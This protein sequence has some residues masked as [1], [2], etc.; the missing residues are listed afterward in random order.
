MEDSQKKTEEAKEGAE[1]P[2][3]SEQRRRIADNKIILYTLAVVESVIWG[4]SFVGT[5]AALIKL[6]PMEVITARWTMAAVILII[7]AAFKIIKVNFKGKD[8]KPV[9]LA[10]LAQPCL[11]SIGEVYGISMTTTSESSIL[12]AMGPIAIMLISVVF[13]KVK[14]DKVT[15]FAVLAAFSGVVLSIVLSDDFSL[16]GKYAG[17]AILVVTVILGAL[18]TLMSNRISDRFTPMEITFVMTVQG[19]I[20]FNLITLIGGRGFEV[21][22]ICLTDRDTMLAVTFLGLGCTVICYIIFN[23]VV[24]KLPAHIAEALQKNLITLT[25]VITGILINGDSWN[26]WT[27]AGLAVMLFGIVLVSKPKGAENADESKE[28]A[29]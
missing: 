26:V 8:M 15:V 22:R 16:G 29:V 18:F 4:F 28:I 23:T 17:Y 13:L 21:Y 3:K 7:M 12:I 1:E 20:F 10:A 9:M 6:T 5:K 19:S 27:I 11:Y 2:Q 24:S 25:G 14:I